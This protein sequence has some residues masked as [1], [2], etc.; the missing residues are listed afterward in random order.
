MQDVF[1]EFEHLVTHLN[2][3][4]QGLDKVLKKWYTILYTPHTH[5]IMIQLHKH[6]ASDFLRFQLHV[7]FRFCMASTNI[8]LTISILLFHMKGN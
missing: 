5:T 4:P 1:N 7:V 3:G 2:H 8:Y 6:F